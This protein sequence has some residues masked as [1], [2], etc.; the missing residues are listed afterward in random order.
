PAVVVAGSLMFRPGSI[1]WAFLQWD[2]YEG[3]AVATLLA[4][5]LIGCWSWY[6]G[7]RCDH[8]TAFSWPASVRGT[9]DAVARSSVCAAS[10]LLL[11]FV[12]LAPGLLQDV[13]SNYES[14]LAWC[15]EM[16][17]RSESVAA[18]VKAIESD[19]AKMQE[20]CALAAGKA[21]EQDQ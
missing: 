17:D 8:P 21:V 20:F 12:A 11:A 6:R 2:A 16:R 15:C 18:A 3:V 14:Q 9:L 5:A 10:F 1:E 4:V 7:G 13:Q 19:P